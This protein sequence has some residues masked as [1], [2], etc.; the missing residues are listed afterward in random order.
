MKDV[1][2]LVRDKI[3]KIIESDG[4]TCKTRILSD[5]EYII[6]LNKKLQEEVNEY[7][8]S[9]E[10]LEIADIVEVL[11]AILDSKHISYDDFEKL[12][13]EKFAKNG[14]FSDKIFLEGILDKSE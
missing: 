11:R 4:R 14:G 10:A 12:R 3:P 7:L 5:D 1:N 13:C 6:E 8:E 9:G 2:K